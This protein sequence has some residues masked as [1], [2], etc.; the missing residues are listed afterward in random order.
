MQARS[1]S[2]GHVDKAD[3]ANAFVRTEQGLFWTRRVARNHDFP[4]PICSESTAVTLPDTI[5]WSDGV[6]PYA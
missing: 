6:T 2:M 1:T 5:K 4:R 3:E